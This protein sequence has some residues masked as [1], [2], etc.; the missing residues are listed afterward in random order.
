MLSISGRRREPVVSDGYRD[1]QTVDQVEDIDPLRTLV[2]VIDPWNTPS[3]FD[4]RIPEVEAFLT[5]MRSSGC[6][7]CFSPYDTALYDNHPCRLRIR[8]AVSEVSTPRPPRSSLKNIPRPTKVPNGEGR[9]DETYLQILGRKIGSRN[10]APR[11]YS[12]HSGLTVDSTL[13]IISYDVI[14]CIRYFSFLDR[15]LENIL[16]CGKHINWCVMNRPNGVE[17][18]RRYGFTNLFVKRDSTIST[19]IPDAPPYCSQQEADDLHFRY[20]ES[21]WAKTF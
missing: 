20:I 13:D 12:I 14:E 7:I 2:I 11:D 3:K 18:W 4:A 1:W 16:F 8:N 6:T 15:P 21:Y 9:E 10:P 5:S 17:E 19:N